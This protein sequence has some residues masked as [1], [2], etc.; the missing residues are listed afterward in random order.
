M[1]AIYKNLNLLLVICLFILAIIMLGQSS[2]SYSQEKT[3]KK[4]LNPKTKAVLINKKS[5][6]IW[7]V[8]STKIRISSKL[9]GV[10]NSKDDK[11]QSIYLE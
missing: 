11:Y 2:N 3:I 9:L 1:E 5:T 6:P 4:I 8:E 7:R 10:I